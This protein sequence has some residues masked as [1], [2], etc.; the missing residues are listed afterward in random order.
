[1][2]IS[3]GTRIAILYSTFVVLMIGLVTASMRK[4]FDLVSDDYYQ[5]EVQYQQVIDASKNQSALETPVALAAA[6]KGVSLFF[7]E[8]FRG[9]E[10]TASVLFY[11]PANNEWDKKLELKTSDRQLQIDRGQLHATLYKVKISWQAE[12]VHYYQE[13]EINLSKL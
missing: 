1:M 9:K 13:A 5:Q 2:T 4:K 12:G 3:W 6:G 8:T 7:P 10:I 11:A